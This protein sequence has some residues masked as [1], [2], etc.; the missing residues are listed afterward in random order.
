MKY[1]HYN[2]S[3]AAEEGVGMAMQT[4]LSAVEP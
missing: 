4:A 3:A 1:T 2:I